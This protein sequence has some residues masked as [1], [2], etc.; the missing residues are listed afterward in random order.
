MRG[1][2]L[3]G[4]CP[5][6]PD[7]TRIA[8]Y[9]DNQLITTKLNEQIKYAMYSDRMLKYLCDRFEWTDRQIECINWQAIE[10]AKRRLDRTRSIWTSKMMHHWLPIG[11]QTARVTG[12]S[13]DGSCPCCGRAHED[14]DHLFTCHQQTAKAARD[15]AA[16]SIEAR[17]IDQNSPLL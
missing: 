10:M 6:Q 7:G 9:I 13:S 1:H 2:V 8:L 5:W 3:S 4:I 16:G 17:L 11:H 15:E 12:I 14:Q